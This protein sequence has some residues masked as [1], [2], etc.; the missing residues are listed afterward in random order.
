MKAPKI[1]KPD[2]QSVRLRGEKKELDPGF[3]KIRASAVER[4]HSMSVLAKLVLVVL[5]SSAVMFLICVAAGD[6]WSF[7][8]YMNNIFCNTI[9]LIVVVLCM[10]TVVNS[11][12]E[13]RRKREEARKILRYNRLIQPD[14]DMYL[15]RKNMVITPNGKSVRKFQIDSRFTVRDMRDMYS[16][17]ELVADVGMSKI[18]RYGHYQTVLRE[19][20]H[21]LVENVDFAYYPEIGEAAMRY[22]NATSYG[23]AALDAV[24]GYEDARAGTKSMRVMVVGMIKDEPEDGRFMD[25]NPAMKNI[26]LV[27]QMINEQEKAVAQYLKL[28]RVLQDED[29]AEQRRRDGEEEDYS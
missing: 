13:S 1:R 18:S 14:V 26:Y 11:N 10:D 7:G 27:H 25:A 29:P 3:G 5:V 23:E 4:S 8:D 24:M 21:K 20:F 12:T 28:I 6:V 19:D 16:P 9:A 17:S 22:L 2:L 15:V